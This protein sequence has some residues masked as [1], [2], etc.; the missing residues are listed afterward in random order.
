M[1]DEAYNSDILVAGG[2]DDTTSGLQVSVAMASGCVGR[3]V[4]STSTGG[5]PMVGAL[6]VA[7]GVAPRVGNPTALRSVPRTTGC[8]RRSIDRGLVPTGNCT[9]TLPRL[10]LVPDVGDDESDVFVVELAFGAE[11]S[12]RL[13]PSSVVAGL[14][15]SA[16][17]L[18]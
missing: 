9:E 4:F 16:D 2:R 1:P 3:D 11:E 17:F 13:F 6:V 10:W 7:T 5:G 18:F 14:S 15:E 8:G 12:D